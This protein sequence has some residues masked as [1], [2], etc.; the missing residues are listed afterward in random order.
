MAESSFKFPRWR[1]R[2]QFSAAEEDGAR[3]GKLAELAVCCAFAAVALLCM[4]GMSG[5]AELWLMITAVGLQLAC[6]AVGLFYYRHSGAPEG[7]GVATMFAAGLGCRFGFFAGNFSYIRQHFRL[8]QGEGAAGFVLENERIF[9]FSLVLTTA[10]LAVMLVSGAARN[11]V[12]KVGSTRFVGIVVF[13]S[14]IPGAVF[15][16]LGWDG[17]TL[18]LAWL[19]S[20]LLIVDLYLVLRLSIRHGSAF[21]AGAL[22]WICISG[23]GLLFVGAFAASPHFISSFSS[24]AVLLCFMMEGTR[25]IRRCGEHYASFY[26]AS[27]RDPLTNLLNRRTLDSVGPTLFDQS[28]SAGRPISVLMLDIDNFKQVNDTYGHAAGDAVLRQFAAVMTSSVRASDLCARYGG[29]EFT[30]V[31]P[32]AS[33][34]PA[35]R[36]AERIRESTENQPFDIGQKAISISVS[37]GASTAF[38]EDNRNLRWLLDAADKNL[39]RAKNSGRNRVMSDPL[40]FRVGL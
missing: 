16:K 25:A 13:A 11:V 6:V 34:A 31:L 2:R 30:V 22:L 5:D 29:E 37:I 1:D 4:S 32:G 39:Y 17:A 15:A 38:P 19:A 33:L 24:S 35:L 10:T 26:S 9:V 23:A 40:E 36:L 7:I 3:P 20:L 28:R 18:F 21:S 12:L 27:E 14:A 8:H